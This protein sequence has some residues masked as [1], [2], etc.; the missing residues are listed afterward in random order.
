MLLGMHIA[1]LRSDWLSASMANA[2]FALSMLSFTLEKML[3]MALDAAAYNTQ[4][5]LQDP[6]KPL[7]YPHA[8]IQPPY[9][10]FSSVYNVPYTWTNLITIM[11]NSFVSSV[12]LYYA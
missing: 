8:G 2:F 11:L 9:R 1:H 12:S 4:I 6:Q 5:C 10:D 3:V 7:F